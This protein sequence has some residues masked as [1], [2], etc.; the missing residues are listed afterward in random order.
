MLQGNNYQLILLPV[1]EE[2]RFTMKNN[3]HCIQLSRSNTNS[4]QSL[5][6]PKYSNTKNDNYNIASSHRH[7]IVSKRQLN[8]KKLLFNNNNENLISSIIKEKT[9]IATLDIRD[10]DNSMANIISLNNDLY[11]STNLKNKQSSNR[12]NTPFSQQ[13]KKMP[14]FVSLNENFVSKLNIEIEKYK[15]N[16]RCGASS[17]IS[18]RGN[19]KRITSYKAKP[20]E[21][22]YSAAFFTTTVPLFSSN[23]LQS[24]GPQEETKIINHYH[25]KNY[26]TKK[27]PYITQCMNKRRYATPIKSNNVYLEEAFN[28]KYVYR[29]KKSHAN[30]EDILLFHN[31]FERTGFGKFDIPSAIKSKLNVSSKPK[32][33]DYS[34]KKD[35]KS[36]SVKWDSI[37]ITK[38][39]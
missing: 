13:K 3:E 1:K 5:N 4:K 19:K 32:L 34:P 11:L 29:Y 9:K 20:N 8:Q 38:I 16:E 23:S 27:M 10:K 35:S 14:H 37:K 15:M 36:F 33:E 31:T 21:R 26:F 25:K 17:S 22:P 6:S 7:V 30:V 18:S 28:T 12:L 24:T 2:K 39:F